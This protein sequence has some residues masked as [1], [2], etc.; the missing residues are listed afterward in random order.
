MN[1]LLTAATGAGLVVLALIIQSLSKNKGQSAEPKKRPKATIYGASETASGYCVPPDET[2][3]TISPTACEM[4][5]AAGPIQVISRSING[6]RLSEL[7]K[8]GPVA[9][10]VG[11]GEEGKHVTAFAEQLNTDTSN[12][13]V[14]SAGMVDCLFDPITL[15]DYMSLVETAVAEIRKRTGMYPVIRGYN[16]F[17]PTTLMTPERLMRVVQFNGALKNWCASN[18]VD[19]ADVYETPF[20]GVADMAPDMIH[21]NKESH[22]AIANFMAARLDEIAGSHGV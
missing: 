22:Q 11:L 5:S 4:M 21:R 6:L 15:E 10:G 12:L 14:V 9:S 2:L 7:M 17:V 3:L 8:G 20:A 19:F 18:S 13:I 1:P 16:Q